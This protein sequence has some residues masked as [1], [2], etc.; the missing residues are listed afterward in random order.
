MSLICLVKIYPIIVT[1][2]IMIGLIYCMF[3]VNVSNITYPIFGHSLF[4]DVIMLFFSLKF[5]FWRWHQALLVNLIF[6]ISIE[7][8]SVN[9]GFMPN[10]KD[11]ITL[12]STMISITILTST[13]L[14]YKHG[15]FK[16]SFKKST[17]NAR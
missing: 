10:V 16:T 15:C 1:M 4:I 5:M 7:W 9:K 11:Y 6:I 12:L 2:S 3:G 13:I 14:Y 8:F 17:R